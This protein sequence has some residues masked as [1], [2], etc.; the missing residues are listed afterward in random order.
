[1]ILIW[2][3]PTEQAE[4]VQP[5]EGQAEQPAEAEV[6]PAEPTEQPAQ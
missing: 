6:A 5:E 4:A 2:L 1:M 3:V